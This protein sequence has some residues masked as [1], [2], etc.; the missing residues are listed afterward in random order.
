MHTSED[1]H[2]FNSTVYASQQS[3]LKGGET[4]RRYDDLPLISERVRNIVKA[5][6]Q[7]EYPSFG[8]QKCFYHSLRHRSVSSCMRKKETLYLLIFFEMLI[9]DTSLIDLQSRNRDSSLL[10][11]KEPSICWGVR[12]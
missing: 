11:C 3:S 7:C 6:E 12:E 5:R 2:N 4:E 9:F 10:R 1:R 8:I